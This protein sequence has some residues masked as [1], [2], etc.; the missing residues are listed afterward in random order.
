[1]FE[2]VFPFLKTYIKQTASFIN[3]FPSLS[4]LL[5]EIAVQIFFFS[6]SLFDEE[7]I[8]KPFFGVPVGLSRRKQALAKS[9]S[10]VCWGGGNY[11]RTMH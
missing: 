6:Q 9:W 7:D 10:Q 1:M 8:E 4:L 2:V 3:C 11:L 5:N